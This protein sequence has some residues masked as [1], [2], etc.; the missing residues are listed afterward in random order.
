[1][2][3]EECRHDSQSDAIVDLRRREAQRCQALVA[4]DYAVLAPL[5]DTA[6][7]H[8]HSTGEMQD[9]ESY[10]RHVQGPVRCVAIE[11]GH[12]DVTVY[13]DMAL[14]SGTLTNTM[15]P[16]VPVA[17]ARVRTQ[18]MQIWLRRDAEWRLLALQATRLAPAADDPA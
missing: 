13:G 8:T 5:L 14:M 18:V 3:S 15:Q 17:A 11:R 6:L 9:K 10:L 7:M 16:P 4:C 2:E 1:M 12:L